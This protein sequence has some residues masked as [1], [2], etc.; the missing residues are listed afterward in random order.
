MAELK[1]FNAKRGSYGSAGDNR[2][3]ITLGFDASA[4]KGEN[5]RAMLMNSA[6]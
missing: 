6:S 5:V 4:T 3:Y 2:P 1:S